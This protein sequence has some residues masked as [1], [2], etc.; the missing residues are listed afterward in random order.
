M[1]L[2]RSIQPSHFT[3]VADHSQASPNEDTPESAKCR[4]VVLKYP[5]VVSHVRLA[6]N[7]VEY[8]LE[9]TN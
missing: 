1:S 7:E 2:Y 5:S 4:L 6:E 8:I 3:V 9:K